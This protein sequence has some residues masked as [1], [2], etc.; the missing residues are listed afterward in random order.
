MKETWRGDEGYVVGAIVLAWLHEAI[1]GIPRSE[2]QLPDKA[3]NDQIGGKPPNWAAQVKEMRLRGAR[4]DGQRAAR[5]IV[6]YGIA[7]RGVEA[8][9]PT[10]PSPSSS[11]SPSSIDSS[12]ISSSRLLDL[13]V[14]VFFVVG[15]PLLT[16]AS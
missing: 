9:A 1:M 14:E 12:D 15:V 4:W 5:V 6:R 11:C 10:Y 2:V 8:S 13:F 7:A 16:D 3:F